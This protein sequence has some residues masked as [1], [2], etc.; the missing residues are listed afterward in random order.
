MDQIIQIMAHSGGGF[1]AVTARLRAESPLL[2]ITLKTPSKQPYRPP[3]SHFFSCSD[4]RVAHAGLFTFGGD[5]GEFIIAL[6][7]VEQAQKQTEAFQ[8]QDITLLLSDYLK[9]MTTRSGK[10]MFYACTDDASLERKY[11]FF[12]KGCFVIKKIDLF[13]CFVLYT[14]VVHSSVSLFSFLDPINNS[15]FVCL[16]SCSSCFFFSSSFLLLYLFYLFFFYIC[17]LY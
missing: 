1:S 5:L 12:F 2:A 7:A 6:A 15:H 17:S 13:L 14:H 8:Q 10:T 4:P 3:S 9:T 11:I 16:L